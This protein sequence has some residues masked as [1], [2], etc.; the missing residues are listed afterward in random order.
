MQIMQDLAMCMLCTCN[1][2]GDSGTFAPVH[3]LKKMEVVGRQECCPGKQL[4]KQHSSWFIEMWL[5][6]DYNLP[7]NMHQ[8]KRPA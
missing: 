5:V 4:A 3:S 7:Y 6:P 1:H 2:N 8:H